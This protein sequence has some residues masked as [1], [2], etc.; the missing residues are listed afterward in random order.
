M[1]ND[2]LKKQLTQA[3]AGG[4][5]TRKSRTQM[6]DTLGDALIAFHLRGGKQSRRIQE[7]VVRAAA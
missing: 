4:L 7:V 3:K 6:F 1:Y 5:R 2:Q